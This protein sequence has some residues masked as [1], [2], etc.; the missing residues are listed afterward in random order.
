MT[1]SVAGSCDRDDAQQVAR[2]GTPEDLA[3]PASWVVLVIDDDPAARK[4]VIRF[5][6]KMRLRN[7]LV[8]AVDGDDAIAKLSEDGTH[9]VL[10]LL[11]L[12]MPGRSGIEVLRWM[13]GRT[14][15]RDV[16]VVVLSGFAELADMDEMYALGIVSYLV[17]PV[18]FPALGDLLR[19]VDLPWMLM[20]PA[21]EGSR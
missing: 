3:D 2:R 18:G 14:R 16:P 10:V 6:E 7:P 13:R 12:K 8:E 11:D 21:V 15:F 20:P 19:Q 5:L 9:P 4:L 17:K 1:G